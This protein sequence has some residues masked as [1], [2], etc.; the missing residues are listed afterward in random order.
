MGPEQA[1]DNTSF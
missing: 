1:V